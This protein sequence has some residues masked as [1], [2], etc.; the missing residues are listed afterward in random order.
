[1]LAAQPAITDA[2]EVAEDPVAIFGKHC[3]FGAGLT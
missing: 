2:S 3:E 1:V